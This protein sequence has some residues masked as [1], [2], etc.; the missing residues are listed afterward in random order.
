MFVDAGK[1][2]E[3]EKIDL[4]S[5]LSAFF[6]IVPWWP[7]WWSNK[8]IFNSNETLKTANQNFLLRHEQNIQL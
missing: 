4:P 7:M 2:L 5:P 1:N 8:T 3:T 6:V